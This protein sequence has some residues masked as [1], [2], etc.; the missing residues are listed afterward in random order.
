MKPD[1]GDKV[2]FKSRRWIV[3]AKFSRQK[4]YLALLPGEKLISGPGLRESN[5]VCTG[6]KNLKPIE[7]NEP[8]KNK[9]RRLR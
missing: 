1:V 5:T 6:Y 9:Q 3:V 7:D 8:I 2:M 4:L